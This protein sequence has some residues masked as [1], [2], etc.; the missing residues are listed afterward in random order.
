M[1]DFKPGSFGVGSNTSANCDANNKKASTNATSHA[2]FFIVVTTVIF[3]IRLSIHLIQLEYKIQ[4]LDDII[5]CRVRE[6]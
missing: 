3:L 4:K 6:P 5:R 2:A 1:T